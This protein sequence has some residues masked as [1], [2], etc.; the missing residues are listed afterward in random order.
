VTS[1]Q[2]QTISGEA[3]RTI[4]KRESLEMF[5]SAFVEEPVLV[6]SVANTAIYGAA[7][8][9]TFFSTTAAIYENIGFTKEETVRQTTFL[10]WKGNALGQKTI[11]GLTVLARDEAGQIERIELYHR[12][13]AIV[14]AFSEE[15]ERRLGDSLGRKLFAR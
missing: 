10:E 11:E 13:L 15:L 8:V 2:E 12:P 5:A 14:V 1:Q 7:A 9:R 3:W 6:A 4:L